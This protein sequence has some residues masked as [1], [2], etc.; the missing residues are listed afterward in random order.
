MTSKPRIIVTVSSDGQINAET[1]GLL[2]EACLDYIAV[3]E[4][5]LAARTVE[6]SYTADYTRVRADVHAVE[7]HRDVERA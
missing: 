2:G 6:S 7:T 5:L 3:L 1:E 4:D